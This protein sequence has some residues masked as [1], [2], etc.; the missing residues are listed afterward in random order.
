[1]WTGARKRELKPLDTRWS[2]WTRATVPPAGVQTTRV[3]R[4][5]TFAGRQDHSAACARGLQGLCIEN[6][7]GQDWAAGLWATDD[8]VPAWV[9]GLETNSARPVRVAAR[10]CTLR[11]GVSA[12][13]AWTGEWHTGGGRPVCA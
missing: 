3:G 6:L 5:T 10:A 13:L 9:S 4:P 12:W 8:A 11:R 7:A 2:P 1:M